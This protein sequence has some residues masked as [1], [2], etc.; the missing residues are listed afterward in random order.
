MSELAFVRHGTLH[1]AEAADME[2][3][4]VDE[5]V[6]IRHQGIMMMLLIMIV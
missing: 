4:S 5:L 1:F 6:D 2:T 3:C